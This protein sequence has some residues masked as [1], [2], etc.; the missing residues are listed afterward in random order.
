MTETSNPDIVDLGAVELQSLI[1]SRKISSREVLTAYLGQIERQNPAVNAI[2]SLQ[3][4]EVLFQ[5]ADALDQQLLQ[6]G[7]VGPLHGI[8]QA[9]KD[10]SPV[11]GM[12]T[13]KGSPNY[14]DHVPT[15]DAAV[16][17]RMRQAG[18]IFVGRTNVPEFGLG[19]HTFNP[20]FGPTRNP[21]NLT[22]SCG[23][24]S[25]GA[26]VALALR[27]LPVA[28]G[29][30]MMGSLRTPA[31]Y[32]NVFGF[33]PSVGCVPHGPGDEL[34]MD[35]FTVSGPMARNVPDLALLLGVQAGLH[36]QVPVSRPFAS[37]TLDRDFKGTKIGWLGDFGGRIPV[38]P[39]LMRVAKASLAHFESL[40]CQ[41]QEVSVDF[42]L[43]LLFEAWTQLRAYCFANT[44]RGLYED[45]ALRKLLKPEAVWECEQGMN[46]TGEQVWRA[47]RIRSD[48]YR[49]VAQ[50][51]TQV[52]FAISPATQVMPFDID[53]HWPRSIN[54]VTMQTYH[55]WMEIMLFT[56]VTGLPSL[57][58]PA[59]FAES[60]LPVGI[61]IIGKP[62]ADWSVLQLGHAYD[63]ASQYAATRSP[64][65]T[66]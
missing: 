18:A 39:E 8:P 15:A 21:F 17:E 44:N 13:T 50:V 35:Q 65:L 12:R 22:K 14:R 4:P 27:M 11:A 53:T 20:I 38:E 25:G 28:D 41:V 43:A 52:D 45:P 2:V 64:L 51:Y 9:P 46:L 42:D 5:Q 57:A 23:G 47:S 33:R 34:F 62:Q 60:G 37:G 31:A 55:Q 16:F 40:G 1:A 29:S 59:G 56:T 63:A 24:S 58:A 49:A 36:A 3:E 19:G 66:T 48:F 54:G 6:G 10:I 26:G 30:D 7:P 32:S 61:Q